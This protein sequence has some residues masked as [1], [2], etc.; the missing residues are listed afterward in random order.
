[1]PRYSTRPARAYKP[2]ICED[3]WY[4]DPLLPC[5]AVSD[6]EAAFTGLLDAKGEEIWRSPNP[7]GFGRDGEW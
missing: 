1:M 7:M 4:S 5:V 2:L 6:H 3:D